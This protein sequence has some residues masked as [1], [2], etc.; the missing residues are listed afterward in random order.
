MSEENVVVDAEV[1]E[2]KEEVQPVEEVAQELTP[3]QKTQAL[4][5]AINGEMVFMRTTIDRSLTQSVQN[6]LN[7]LQMPEKEGVSAEDR[8]K[9]INE[10][11]NSELAFMKVTLDRT[12]MVGVQNIV[13]IV[14]K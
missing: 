4:N 10:A 2:V 5:N 13:N 12:T 11:I 3:E 7:T 8:V 9:A 6:I 1:T 14:T